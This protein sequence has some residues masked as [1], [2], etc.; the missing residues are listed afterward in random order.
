MA[1]LCVA[2]SGLQR[3]LFRQGLTECFQEKVQELTEMG[4]V[5]LAIDMTDTMERVNI[6]LRTN[7]TIGVQSAGAVVALATIL[8]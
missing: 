8:S 4:F 7:H 5:Q 1:A 2:P 6:Q 3:S